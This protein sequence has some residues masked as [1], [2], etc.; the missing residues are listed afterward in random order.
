M[1]LGHKKCWKCGVFKSVQEYH[2]SWDRKDTY[3]TICIP[4]A[5]IVRNALNKRTDRT[6]PFELAMQRKRTCYSCKTEKSLVLF[7][8]EKPSKEGYGSM[9]ADCSRTKMKERRAYKA[10]QDNEYYTRMNLKMYGLTLEQFNEIKASQ[11]NACAIC[12]TPELELIHRLCVDH[13]HA[14]M[15]IR[16]LLCHACNRAIGLL[17]DDPDVLRSAAEYLTITRHESSTVGIS[18]ID[19]VL[20]TAEKFAEGADK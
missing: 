18:P 6:I 1:E 16:G 13:N 20:R 14:T 15:N 17:K 8:K 11:N 7:K 3:K 4:C 9:C 12:K 10:K 2:H 5:R 19:N